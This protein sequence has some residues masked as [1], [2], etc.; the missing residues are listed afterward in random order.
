MANL[1]HITDPTTT[2]GPLWQNDSSNDLGP[3]LGFAWSPSRVEDF[4]ARR[5]RPALPHQRPQHVDCASA[6][7]SPDFNIPDNG[8]F[9]NALTTIAASNS[10]GA[11]SV[12]QYEHNKT[13]HALQYNLS[14]Q[15][16]FGSATVVSI[17]YAGSRG[18]NLLS[19]GEMNGPRAEWDGQSLAY[20][21]TARV[22]NP[23]FSNITYFANNA[24]SWYNG[25]LTSFQR[26]CSAGCQTQVSYTFSRAISEA[27]GGQTGQQISAGG[28]ELKYPLDMSVNNGLSGY[29]FRHLLTVNY[30]WNLPLGVAVMESPARCFRVG[31]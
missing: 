4:F 22:I 6:P 9:P 29:D 26:R 20:P 10:A 11:V 1:R 17:T 14:L 3:R 23:N 25:L 16:Q 15:Q 31:K 30:S 18:I 8:N 27:D 19:E 21:L 12:I 13:P 2:L 28:A 24:N 5:S 7:I